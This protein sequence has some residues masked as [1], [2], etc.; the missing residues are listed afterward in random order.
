[1]TSK[2]ARTGGATHQPDANTRLAFQRTFLACERT[3]MAWVR[4]GL[5]L[6]S[7]GFGIAKFFQYLHETQGEKAPI[8]GPRTVGMLMISVGLVALILANVQHRGAMAALREEFPELQRS[9]AGATSVVIMALGVL[10]LVGAV[11]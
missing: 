1:V 7:F 5:A 11:F 4:T 8:M 2:K 3:Q 10:A 9:T 6:I